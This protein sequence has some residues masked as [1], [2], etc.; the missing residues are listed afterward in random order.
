MPAAYFALLIPIVNA[1]GLSNIE[2][3]NT[4]IGTSI[5]VLPAGIVA[6]PL[7]GVKT[8]AVPKS[9]P[10]F[11]SPLTVVQSIFTSL[12]VELV[13]YI[14][15][16]ICGSVPSVAGR[17]M[18]SSIKIVGL[19]DV[20]TINASPVLSVIVNGVSSGVPAAYFALL[21]SILNASGLSNI[22]SANTS[23]G[24]STNVLPAGIVAV[25]LIGVKT[26]AVPKSS[27]DF[28]SPLTVVQSI[29]TSLSVELVI[30]ILNVICGSVP[31][32]AKGG[33]PSLIQAVGR[34]TSG[35]S[36]SEKTSSTFSGNSLSICPV[37]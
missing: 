35:S 3:S 27:P 17:G 19:S 1:S 29:F 20:S 31:S 37:G 15:N 23:I 10:D 33:M 11:A 8:P 7:I 25:P 36:F 24:T 6:V 9:S 14:L 12:S 16:V 34:I 2:S 18:P 28:A 5:N 22:E 26:P 32:I 30:Y 21:I 4:S 13:I